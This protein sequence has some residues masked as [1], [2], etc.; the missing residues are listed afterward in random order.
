MIH[1][2]LLFLSALAAVPIVLHMLKRGK[3]KPITFPA[4]RFL[5]EKQTQSRRRMHLQNI[6]LLLLPAAW[7]LAQLGDTP[8]TVFAVLG[9]MFAWAMVSG[10]ESNHRVL[11]EIVTLDQEKEALLVALSARSDE[12][13]QANAELERRVAERTRALLYKAQHDALSA[14]LE[15]QRSEAKGLKAD[16]GSAQQ[17]AANTR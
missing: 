17:T 12:V 1:A 8:H 14:Q 9:A 13:M 15:Q 11:R 5:L 10:H 6:L 7:R 4:M 3:P 2:Y 16:L